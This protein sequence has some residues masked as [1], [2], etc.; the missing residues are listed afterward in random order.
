MELNDFEVHANECDY[1][2]CAMYNV[3]LESGVWKDCQTHLATVK[4]DSDILHDKR[5]LIDFDSN[6]S[7]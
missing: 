4:I 7:K 1:D 5:Y 6:T 2:I 3:L